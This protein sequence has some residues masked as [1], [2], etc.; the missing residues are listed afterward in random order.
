MGERERGR[1]GER[2]RE[3]V[4]VWAHYNPDDMPTR[5]VAL[6]CLVGKSIHFAR[7]KT[8]FQSIRQKFRLSMSILIK[9]TAITTP[10]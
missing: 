9:E 1:E 7:L 3:S 4:C 2:E 10:R 6:P 5:H 8:L